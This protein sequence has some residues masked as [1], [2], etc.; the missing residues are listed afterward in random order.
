MD[1][2]RRSSEVGE[3]VEEVRPPQYE[4]V[5]VDEKKNKKR[6]WG[7]NP[8]SGSLKPGGWGGKKNDMVVR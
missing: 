5:V 1:G 7:R 8:R 3:E 2:R 6:I 4:S